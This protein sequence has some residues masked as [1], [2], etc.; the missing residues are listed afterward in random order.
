MPK[1]TSMEVK[2]SVADRLA[3]IRKVVEALPEGDQ[4]REDLILLFDE[5]DKALEAKHQLQ[6]ALDTAKWALEVALKKLTQQNI[7][8]MQR[9]PE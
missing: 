4:D 2:L 3:R 7:S 9:P 6:G 5:L 1:A 8:S